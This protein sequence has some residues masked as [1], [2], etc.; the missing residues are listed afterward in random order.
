MSKSIQGWSNAARNLLQLAASGAERETP[1]EVRPGTA[2]H[3]A[4]KLEPGT[5]HGAKTGTAAREQAAVA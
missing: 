4:A 3:P 2:G 5:P 1:A